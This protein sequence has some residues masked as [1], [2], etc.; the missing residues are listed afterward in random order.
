MMP[1]GDRFKLKAD[2]EDGTTPIANLL[3]EAVA[4]AKISGLQKGAILYLWRR[5]YGWADGDKR[6]KERKIALS[7]WLHALDSTKAR[8]SSALS[9]LEG[10]NIIKRRTTD[11][12]GGYYYS[13]NTNVASWNSDC[14]N[15]ARLSE[16][17]TVTDF[18]TVTQSG[19]VTQN[20]NS[21]PK[22][23]QLLE[24][25]TPSPTPKKRGLP[26]TATVTQNV[27]EQLPKT[28]PPTL[29]KERVKK[30]IKKGYG[31]IK[32]VFLSKVEYDKLIDLFGEEGV[33]YRIESLSLYIG[34]KGDK[35][36]SHYL[37]ILNWER[38][39]KERAD[40]THRQNARKVR[41]HDKYTHPDE[42]RE[43]VG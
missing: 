35:Y 42:N 4:M 38:M 39:K 12:W 24:A 14:I 5:T 26:K 30:E 41:T 1:K 16:M 6:V 21:P 43:E 18:G 3:L 13:I 15:L 31:D 29:Y 7:E 19:T 17:I 37:T 8:V 2:P 9:D 22:R 11:Q 40:G 25:T 28:E 20:D 34:S 33:R 23:Q 27:T 32:N 36:R 10:K